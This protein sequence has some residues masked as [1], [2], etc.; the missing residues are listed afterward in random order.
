MLSLQMQWRHILAAGL[1]FFCFSWIAESSPSSF[2]WTKMSLKGL[3]KLKSWNKSNTIHTSVILSINSTLFMTACQCKMSST[4]HCS[5]HWGVSSSTLLSWQPT[6]ST[7]HP[8]TTASATASALASW[9]ILY[10]VRKSCTWS[11]VRARKMDLPFVV[12]TAPS[13]SE[14]VSSGKHYLV[15][16]FQSVTKAKHYLLHH[17]GVVTQK[18]KNG[19]KKLLELFTFFLFHCLSWMEN[20]HLNWKGTKTGILRNVKLCLSKSRLTSSS[21]VLPTMLGTQSFHERV[22]I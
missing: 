17:G 20:A 8:P 1:F 19:C 9:E 18:K 12:G 22:P 3:Q 16:D 15:E 10:P 4:H 2:W 14:L 5:F 6:G 21:A 11:H 7:I 13:V